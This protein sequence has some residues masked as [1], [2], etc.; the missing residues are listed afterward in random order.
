MNT[1]AH[2]PAKHSPVPVNLQE[3]T[4]AIQFAAVPAHLFSGYSLKIPQFLLHQTLKLQPHHR[5]LII[6]QKI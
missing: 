6:L 2:V 3:F 4:R 5:C 1:F